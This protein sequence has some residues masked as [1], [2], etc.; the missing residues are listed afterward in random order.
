[1]GS[2]VVIGG[3][4]DCR[5]QAASLRA[6]I[7]ACPEPQQKVSKLDKPRAFVMSG[8]F[9]RVQKAA[10]CGPSKAMMFGPSQEPFS[11]WLGQGCVWAAWS[12]PGA[13]MMPPHR[14]S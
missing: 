12:D 6:P 8:Q 14:G 4:W 13:A 7:I 5:A 11:P 10:W 1:M 3:G 9:I 2:C